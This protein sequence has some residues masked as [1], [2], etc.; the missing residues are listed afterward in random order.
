MRTFLRLLSRLKLLPRNTRHRISHEA[1]F[2]SRP[3]ACPNCRGRL[4]R[5]IQ[6]ERELYVCDGFYGR[7]DIAL[8]LGPH[9][10]PKM[11][12]AILKR[13]PADTG[14]FKRLR[15]SCETAGCAAGKDGSCGEHGT[16]GPCGF[17]GEAKTYGQEWG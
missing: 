10:M 8:R 14:S 3:E 4:V 17:S 9:W 7:E 15:V 1:S 6:G 2:P 12:E 11:R 16:Y 13:I 5:V